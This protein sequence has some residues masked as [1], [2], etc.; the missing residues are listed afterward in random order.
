MDVSGVY[1]QT[2]VIATLLTNVM[3]DLLQLL[4]LV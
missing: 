2:S 1:S 4:G 3:Q